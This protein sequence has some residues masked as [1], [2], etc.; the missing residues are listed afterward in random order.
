MAMMG[1]KA[2]VMRALLTS[3]L[4]TASRVIMLLSACLW[5]CSMC[6]GAAWTSVYRY[7]LLVSSL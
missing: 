7:D 1:L 3:R 5:T 2:G 6:R 4:C